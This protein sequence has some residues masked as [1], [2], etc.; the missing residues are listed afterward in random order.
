MSALDDARERLRIAQLWR[1]LGLRGEAGTT[2][3]SP[4][5]EDRHPSFSVFDEGRRFKDFG[6]PEHHGDAV[7][8]LAIARRLSASEAARELIRMAGLASDVPPAA[9]AVKIVP[10]PARLG[11]MP[12]D[13]A[14]TWEEGLRFLRNSKV[15]QKRIAQWRGWTPEFVAALAQDGL[16]G[17]PVHRGVRGTGFPVHCPERGGAAETIGFHFRFPARGGRA[18]WAFVPQGVPALPFVVGT[19]QGAKL[20]VI[21]EGQWDGL[22]LCHAAG[23]FDH[24]AA[25]PGDVAVIG[26]R[27]ASGW[28]AF[29]DHYDR[30][31]PDPRPSCLLLPDR[32][33]AGAEWTQARGRPTFLDAL[34][35]RCR[36]V[37]VRGCVGGKDLN[38]LHRLQPITVA[39]IGRIFLAGGLT[40]ERG[41]VL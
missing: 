12:A 32:D 28:R 29:V 4:F 26:I 13:A 21:T 22:T 35:K 19:F 24:D 39:E 3:C 20:L 11:A 41:R 23:W 2:C 34:R 16:M 38:D 17:M 25:W 37:V 15:Q 27:S 30:H 7:D 40:D 1:M 33:T 8:F 10:K 5:R 14:A 9:G 31:W 36:V 18:R 6:C